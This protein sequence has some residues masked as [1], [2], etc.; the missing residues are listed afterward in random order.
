MF[1][2]EVVCCRMKEMLA[3]GQVATYD[4]MWLIDDITVQRGM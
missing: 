1:I 4:L 2:S 3:Q